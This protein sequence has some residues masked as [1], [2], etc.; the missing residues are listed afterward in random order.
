MEDY[1]TE[2]YALSE[3]I[4]TNISLHLAKGQSLKTTI[5]DVQ[6]IAPGYYRAGKGTK[7]MQGITSID[8]LRELTYM[9]K[10]EQSSFI[11]IRDAIQWDNPD[12]EVY[13]TFSD[14]YLQKKFLEG[15]KLLEAKALVKRTKRSHYMINP[16]A[17]ITFDYK[18][19]LKLWEST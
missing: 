4:I 10:V 12:G 2:E 5:E 16:N 19:A 18:L 1:H 9:S 17:L 6:K 7:N 8:L 15:F 3:A 14:K 13:I 11:T